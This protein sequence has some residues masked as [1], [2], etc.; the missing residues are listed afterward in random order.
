MFYFFVFSFNTHSFVQIYIFNE[1]IVNGHIQPNLGDLCSSVAESLDDKVNTSF[2]PVE[3]DWYAIST[4]N[5]VFRLLVEFYCPLFRTYQTCGWWWNRWQMCCWFQLKTHSRVALLLK[6]RWHLYARGS[7]FLRTGK[8]ASS[9]LFFY[10]GFAP[11]YYF[12]TIGARLY[13]YIVCVCS[14]PAIKTT[15]WSQCL[16]TCIRPN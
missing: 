14:F 15:P 3:N 9:F 1:K 11:F 8:S 7:T 13:S 16:G 5:C 12:D 4:W 2:V 10:E 6:C